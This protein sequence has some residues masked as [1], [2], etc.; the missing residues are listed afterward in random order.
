MKPLNALVFGSVTIDIITTIAAQAI[1]RVTM[2]NATTSFLM[3]EQGRKIEAENIST[4]IGG[5]AANVCVS[6]ARQ[7]VNAN[8]AAL[9]GHDL[10]A[11]KIRK[12]LTDEGINTDALTA[13]DACETGIGVL[14]SAHDHNAAIFTHRGANTKLTLEQLNTISFEARDLVYIAP[15]SGESATCFPHIVSKA[16]TVGAFIATNPGI[17]QLSAHPADFMGVISNVN[18]L[19]LNKTELMALFPYLAGSM[20]S[21]ASAPTSSFDNDTP[22]LLATGLK[23]GALS[24]SLI[25]VLKAIL[26]FG[27]Q[28][29]AVTDGANGAYL[30]DK[31]TLYHVPPRKVILKGTAGAGDSFA[32]TLA[33]QLSRG[34]AAKTALAYASINAASV[35]SEVDTMTG[36]LQQKELEKRET[37]DTIRDWPLSAKTQ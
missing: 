16:K 34:T 35:V 19:T 4:F 5:G 14:I 15:L 21:K 8:I 28:Y 22:K 6:M 32:S 10:N 30:M 9:T 23:V 2:Q 3:L 27:V 36:L 13:I 26:G 18:L 12:K 25:D 1:E 20:S 33:T 17:R 37:T 11:K 31:N 24:A 29:V 7:G